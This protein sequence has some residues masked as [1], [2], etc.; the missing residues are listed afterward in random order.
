MSDRRTGYGTVLP[1]IPDAVKAAD[2][3]IIGARLQPSAGIAFKHCSH[4]RIQICAI[5]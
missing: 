2:S 1:S 4:A 3:T 5:G